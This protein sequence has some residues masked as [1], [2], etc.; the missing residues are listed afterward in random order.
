MYKIFRTLFDKIRKL[1]R[2]K[3]KY[4]LLNGKDRALVNLN[5]ELKK[6]NQKPLSDTLLFVTYYIN[7]KGF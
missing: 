6:G 1:F 2:K 5:V 4:I 3:P 7:V